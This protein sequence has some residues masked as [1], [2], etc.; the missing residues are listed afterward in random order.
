MPIPASERVIYN[1]NP[2]QLVICQLRFPPVLKI[3]A[4][5]PA[6]FQDRIRREFPLF[7]ISQALAP[8]VDVP[9]PIAQIIGAVTAGARSYE[10]SSEDAKWKLTLSKESMAMACEQ[11]P[12]WENFRARFEE[13][14]RGLIDL[15]C[16]AFFS[17]IGLRYR[18][19]IRRS[20]LGLSNTKWSDLLSPYVSAELSSEVGDLVED[21]NHQILMRFE[22]IPGNVRILH[23]IGKDE[24]GESCYLIDNDFFI[25]RKTEITNAISF[26]DHFHAVSGKLFRW[27]INERL[28]IAM[29]PRVL[30]YQHG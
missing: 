17:R 14:F 29:E 9:Q 23:G 12:Q 30:H 16:P 11:Y 6:A 18:N 10:F 24:S 3:E 27:C 26:L 22:D 1:K 7:N 28:H 8:G 13:P 21:S 2:L 15:Y 20:S 19:V 25:D 5:M 4:E